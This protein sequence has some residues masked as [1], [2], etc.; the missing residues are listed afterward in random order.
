MANAGTY[1]K[2]FLVFFVIAVVIAAYVALMNTPLGKALNAAFGLIGGLLNSIDA[3]IESCNT[4]G[5]FNIDHCFLGVFSVGFAILYA[6]FRIVRFFY[7]GGG[8]LSDE[9]AK[10]Q[11]LEPAKS[12]DDIESEVIRDGKLAEVAERAKANGLSDDEAKA[13]IEKAAARTLV[14]KIVDTVNKSS[15]S[16]DAIKEAIA[17]QRASYSELNDNIN[18]DIGLNTDETRAVDDTVNEFVEPPFA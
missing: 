4:Y 8:T 5:W 12:Q 1:I 7:K 13:A 9:V 18:E 11:A 6:T 16:P 2:V 15:L 14:S 17:Q 3:E 10:Q